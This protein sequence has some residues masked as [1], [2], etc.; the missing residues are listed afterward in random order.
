MQEYQAALIAGDHGMADD[1][2]TQAHHMLDSYLDHS[3][4]AALAVRALLP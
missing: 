1:L 2:R 3:G 4:E